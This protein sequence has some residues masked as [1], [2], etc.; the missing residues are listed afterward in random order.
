VNGVLCSIQLRKGGKKRPR[1]CEYARF[2]VNDAP[3]RAKVA[4]WAIRSGR[5]IRVYVIPL[6][7]LRNIASVY[8]PVEGNTPWV[9]ATNPVKTGLGIKMRGT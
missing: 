7:H 6:T 2:D 3:K 5:S 4:L 1:G 8:F 9:T